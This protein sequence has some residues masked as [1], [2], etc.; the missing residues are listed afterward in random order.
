MDNTN[1]LR[2]LPCGCPCRCRKNHFK[3]AIETFGYIYNLATI[4]DATIL[5]GNTIN[6]S[7]NGPLQGINHIIGAEG[8]TVTRNGVFQIDYSVSITAGVGASVALAVNGVIQPSTTINSLVAL[9][10]LNGTAMLN[11]NAGDV[12]TLVNNSLVSLTLALSPNVS[13]QLNII[14]LS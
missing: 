14:Q 12:V 13:A 6:F 9:G 1:Q 5:G 2:V 8:V 11:L 4:I 10:R 7:S 3:P